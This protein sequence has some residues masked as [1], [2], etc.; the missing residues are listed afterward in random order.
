MASES[1]NLK[2]IPKSSK[3]WEIWYEEL[4]ASS[5]N[6]LWGDANPDQ[7]DILSLIP[8]KKPEVSDMVAG[9]IL[10]TNLSAANQRVFDNTR[11]H[12]A[13]DVKE[14]TQISAYA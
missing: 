14:S 8:S 7:P 4:K 12:Y 6:E 2:T 1:R 5:F 3:N 10:Y 13:E 9:T 11:K